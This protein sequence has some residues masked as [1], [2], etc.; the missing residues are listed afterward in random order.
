V[1]SHAMS[2]RTREI[3]LRLALG[4]RA[5]QVRRMV[6]GQ[7]LL[8]VAAG[9]LV[10]LAGASALTRFMSTLLHGVHPGDPATFA[11]VTALLVGVALLASW[12]P[13]WRASRVDPMSALRDD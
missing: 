2:R 13:A 6:M 8:R 12:V 1:L 4:A 3:G 5:G 9:L 7:T 10:G 11:I